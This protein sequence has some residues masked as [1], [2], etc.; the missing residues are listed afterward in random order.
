MNKVSPRHCGKWPERQ[1]VQKLFASGLCSL[2]S[3]SQRKQ[4]APV[5]R[6]TEL[7][8]RKVC[9]KWLNKMQWWATR[10]LWHYFEADASR[11]LVPGEGAEQPL[12]FF[13]F[14]ESFYFQNNGSKNVV[15]YLLP[16][17]YHR[18]IATYHIAECSFLFN[19]FSSTTNYSQFC[20]PFFLN[21]SQY[22]NLF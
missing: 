18:D 2:S 15:K 1:V 9:E 6:N 14:F 7:L 10:G 4:Q 11:F 19:R 13:F 3:G 20:P 17:A 12:H 16:T 21:Y 8:V 22:F 5:G